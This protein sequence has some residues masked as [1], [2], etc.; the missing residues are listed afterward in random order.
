MSFEGCESTRQGFLSSPAESVVLLLHFFQL[1]EWSLCGS[2]SSA[3]HPSCLTVVTNAHQSNPRT[4]SKVQSIVGMVA[5]HTVATVLRQ[6][7]MGAGTRLITF[8]LLFSSTPMRW[9]HPLFGW[10]RP[11]QPNLELPFRH[12][13]RFVALD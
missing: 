5:G 12:A 9:C 7:E 2:Q 3:T 13:R 11:P 1:L 8:S 4:G 10:V 6:R